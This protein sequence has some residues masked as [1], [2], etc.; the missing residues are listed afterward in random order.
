[1]FVKKTFEST[2]SIE[3]F[4]EALRRFK[5]PRIST[6]EDLSRFELIGMVDDLLRFDLET[7]TVN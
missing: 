5:A 6:K 7:N 2:F 1:M 3:E 4:S